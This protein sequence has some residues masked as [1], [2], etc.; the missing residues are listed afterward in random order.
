MGYRIDFAQRGPTMS[1]RV[2]GKSSLPHAERIAREI[3][4]EAARRTVE[5]LIIDVRGLMDRV[6]ILGTLVLRACAPK[7]ERKVALIDT[8]DNSRYH[9][10]SQGLAQRRGD[11]ARCFDEP[12]AAIYTL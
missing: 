3:A 9:A 4:E 1:A 7:P 2:S 6:G 10:V 5:Q 8:L 12:Q 11:A